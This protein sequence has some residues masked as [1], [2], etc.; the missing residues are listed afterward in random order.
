[1]DHGSQA[2]DDLKAELHTSVR[3]LKHA[4]LAATLAM[5]V[6]GDTPSTAAGLAVS[7]LS[8]AAGTLTDPAVLAG[9]PVTAIAFPHI[10]K[11]L[12]AAAY[13]MASAGA[14]NP[15]SVL[16]LQRCVADGG[17]GAFA[18]MGCL[19][20][21]DLSAPTAPAALLAGESVA[22]CC[23]WGPPHCSHVLAAGSQVSSLSRL[24]CIRC[25]VVVVLMASV[26]LRGPLTK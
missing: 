19:A 8:S 5:P 9:R 22:L 1:M 16:A 23:A 20:I 7:G 6:A 3:Q 18:S 11:P 2:P 14:G 15:G 12:V 24:Q 21:W 25:P 13:G 10:G 26:L 17:P 4:R